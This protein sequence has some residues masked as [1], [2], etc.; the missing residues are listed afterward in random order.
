[1]PGVPSMAGE[2]IVVD[3]YAF[4]RSY[5]QTRYQMQGS[6]ELFLDPASATGPVSIVRKIVS[7]ADDPRLHAKLI[8]VEAE[9]TGPSYHLQVD[10]T[11]EVVAANLGLSSE[12]IGNGTLDL[13]I[14]QDSFRVERIEF[15]GS[16]PK[17]GAAAVRLVLTNYNNVAPIDGPAA[18]QFDLPQALLSPGQ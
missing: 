6:S 1:M 14:Y 8:G 10:V 13:W 16:D 2:V 4:V 7:I 15:H 17:A 9:P 5:G 12:T 18:N 3:P 11:P